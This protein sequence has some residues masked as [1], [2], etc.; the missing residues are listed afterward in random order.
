M[1]SNK[2]TKKL[3]TLVLIALMLMNVIPVSASGSPIDI[4][5]AVIT[6]EGIYSYT[7]K[8]LQPEDITIED[9]GTLLTEGTD[10]QIVV[11]GE[12]NG[13][14]T[15]EEIKNVGTYDNATITITGMGDYF[16]VIKKT[17]SISVLSAITGI[18]SVTIENKPY[19]GNN[20]APVLSITLY[21]MVNGEKL[22]LDTDY[23]VSA[24]F[25]DAEVGE[26]KLVTVTIALKSTSLANNYVARTWPFYVTLASITEPV[27]TNAPTPI[28]TPTPTSKPTMTP[29]TTP[30]ETAKPTVTPMV[31]TEL[32]VTP[33]S[34]PVVK[35]TSKAGGSGVANKS[36]AS[37][38][39][40]SGAAT[41][42]MTNMFLPFVTMVLA[43]GVLVGALGAKKRKDT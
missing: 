18:D 16:G 38:T 28:V 3:V 17:Q 20:I 23:S 33:S 27:P 2:P 24:T 30:K 42:D 1:T 8:A 29:T 32:T 12:D 19:D 13:D 31:T 39:V 21:G 6:W 41:G 25:E 9:N 35:P 4:T 15:Y 26:D 7:G 36:N 5:S 10:Y 34:K 43:L 11:D 14:G 37:K 22:E 40:T